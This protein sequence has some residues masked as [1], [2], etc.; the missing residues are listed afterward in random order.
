ML[1]DETAPLSWY[2][3]TDGSVLIVKPPYFIVKVVDLLGRKD[4]SSHSPIEKWHKFPA[5]ATA[6]DLESK[7]KPE[8]QSE[9]PDMRIHNVVMFVSDGP[10]SYRKL[11]SE[12]REPLLQH[13]G[14]D[15]TVH[16]IVRGL[17][18]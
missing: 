3:V 12:G 13:L 4:A 15:K 17:S 7:V 11:D 16:V 9:W 18:I 2:G 5:S 6:V 1:A 14:E 10:E 8:I